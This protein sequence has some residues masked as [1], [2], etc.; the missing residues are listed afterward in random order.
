[1][2]KTLRWLQ[3]HWLLSL[4]I[5]GGALVL[6]PL[7]HAL[8]HPQSLAPLILTDRNGEVLYTVQDPAHGSSNYVPLRDIPTEAIHALLA[9]EDRSFYT[10][11]GISIRGIARAL[12]NNIAAGHVVEGGSTLTQQYVR[13][14]MQPTHRTV[15]WKIEEAYL[16][17]KL[18][19]VM[20]KEQILEG[21]LNRAFFGRRAEGIGAAA[22]A[23]FGK[24]VRELSLPESAFLI[25]LVQAPSALDPVKNFSDA[26]DRQRHVLQ[27]MRTEGFLTDTA[28]SEAEHVPLTIV[29]E[30]TDIRAPHFVFWLLQEQKNLLQHGGTVRT[31]LDLSLQT[32]IETIVDEQLKKLKEKNVTSA[33]VVVLDA[34]TGD[35]LS[36]VGSRDYF[37]DAHDG[38]VNVAVSPRQPG[39][40][41]KP[42][43]YALALA[44]GDTPATTVADTEVQFLTEEGNPYT[45]RNYDFNEHGLVRYRDALANSY[46]IAAV[47]VLERV[48][49]ERLLEFLRSVGLTTLTNT[50][51][52]YGLSLTLGSGEVQLLE[53]ARAYGIFAR[54]GQTLTLRSLLS[55]P[56][57]E[58]DTRLDPRTAWLI[59]NIL[60]D[61]SARVAEFGDDNPLMFDFPVAAKTG[62]TRNSR[63]NWTIGYTPSRI[64]GVWV[65]N[66]DNTPMKGTSGITG[67]GPIFHDA[68]IAAESGIATEDFE[69][70]AGIEE[71]DVCRLS[72][73]LPT[74]ECPS[75]I[76]EYFAAGTV[77]QE[78]DSFYRRIA[79]DMRNNLL[80]TP[81]CPRTV[82]QEKIFTL[83]PLEVKRWAHEHGF[84]EPPTK[85]SPLCGGS[86]LSNSTPTGGVTITSLHEGE[87]IRLN[88]LVPLSSQTI[89]LKASADNAPDTLEWHVNG[90]TVGEGS[91]P[92]YAL[93]WTPAAGLWTI[94]AVSQHEHDVRHIEV[95]ER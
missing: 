7:P 76:H 35:I 63:D 82:V 29:P 94:E 54:N 6:W 43:T 69:R 62:T 15:F 44:R 75:I 52:H 30:R 22:H 51:N 78:H 57:G 24:D 83:F 89:I 39:S 21:Y 5:A 23:I 8:V 41:L 70:P 17:L 59:T 48:G 86:D 53:L 61:A 45:P 56:T 34:K 60:S 16:A 95:I 72:G 74:P 28:R 13:L 91:A 18:E 2:T 90:K 71:A 85:S 11:A 79:I 10:H 87:S 26:K 25:G 32:T 9:T 19:W 46:N 3:Q 88:P 49:V 66:A 12:W 50:P 73:L 55:D 81:A 33:A 77:P 38:A 92:D 47:K 36:M 31:T 40:A 65:G 20:S 1:M 80:A 58:S 14:I 4:I 42:F 68:M 93:P 37:D 84:E 27:A 67:A 64:V